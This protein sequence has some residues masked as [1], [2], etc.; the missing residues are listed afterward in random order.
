MNAVASQEQS[1]ANDSTADDLPPGVPLKG[2]IPLPRHRP[3]IAVLTNVAFAGG[4][5]TGAMAA[6]IPLPRARPASAPEPAPV[7]DTP[8]QPY[9][10]SQFH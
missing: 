2:K 3:N 1:A 9:D 7:S 8:Y 10:P 4:P 6:N 5:P